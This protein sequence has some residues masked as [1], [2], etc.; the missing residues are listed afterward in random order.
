[1]LLPPLSQ[2]CYKCFPCSGKPVKIQGAF[3]FL[4]V[5]LCVQRSSIYSSLVILGMNIHKMEGIKKISY[6]CDIRILL[7]WSSN[8]SFN[9]LFL[10]ILVPSFSAIHSKKRIAISM[11]HLSTNSFELSLLLQQIQMFSTHHILD[12]LI[13]AVV[14]LDFQQ[15]IAEIQHIKAPLL[16]QKHDD[17]TASPVQAVP[18]ALPGGG[19]TA[20]SRL[21][22]QLQNTGT[23]NTQ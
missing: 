3:W 20:Q 12:N 21:Q 11:L 17:H 8:S 6:I 23:V 7:D 14:L 13:F 18:K 2:Q 15:V 4:T 19:N 1:M 10:K 5:L 22:L 16:S 9:L